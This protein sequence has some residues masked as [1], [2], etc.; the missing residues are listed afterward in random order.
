[1]GHNYRALIVLS[2]SKIAGGDDCSA[3]HNHLQ[4]LNQN[5]VGP[6]FVLHNEKHPI[7]VR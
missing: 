3:C 2:Y 7:A 4:E 5:I 6:G 1:L